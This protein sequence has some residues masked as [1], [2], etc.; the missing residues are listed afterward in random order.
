MATLSETALPVQARD[1]A[2]VRRRWIG[3]YTGP[4]SYSPGGIGDPFLPSEVEM[5]AI[6]SFKGQAWNS[7]TAAV[8]ILIYDQVNQT[9]RWFIPNTGAEVA[10]AQ[11]L[12]GF[13]A[14]IEVV[15]R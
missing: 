12:S 15:G 14:D 7:G 10:G 8:R 9:V 3:R 13:V 2:G 1:V 6:G 4:A 5:G 11:D